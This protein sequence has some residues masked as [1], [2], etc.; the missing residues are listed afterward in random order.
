VKRTTR[1]L[2][3]RYAIYAALLVALILVVSGIDLR[4]DWNWRRFFY[5][6]GPSQTQFDRLDRDHDGRIVPAEAERAKQ[7]ELMDHDEDGDGAVVLSEYPAPSY[8]RLLLEGIGLTLQVSLAALLIALPLGV[9]IG[10]CRTAADPGAR[11]VGFTYVEIFRG[12]PLLVQVMI[13][14]FVLATPLGLS[15]FWAAVGALSCFAASY[16]AEIVRAGIQ[17]V[18]RGQMEAARSLGLSHF[19]SLRFVILPQAIRRVLPPLASEFIA[20]VKDSSLASVIGLLELTKKTRE[21]A[22]SSYL[23]FEPWLTTAV[24]Y[25]TINVILSLGVRRLEKRLGV[26]HREEAIR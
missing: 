20:L 23:T 1:R 4:Y 12:T 2:V 22:N 25:L 19:Q 3:V 5:G 21:V 14:W 7:P 11:L 24:L 16:I 13:W 17:G 6:D 26:A 9:V 15:V 8:F 10:M 18:D